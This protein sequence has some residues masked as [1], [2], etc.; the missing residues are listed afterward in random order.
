MTEIYGT[1]GPAC[2]DRATLESMLRAGMTGM[3]LN[4][5]HCDLADSACMIQAFHEAAK[6]AGTAPQL[7]I[8]IQGPELRLGDLDAPKALRPGT[9]VVFGKN[10][11]PVPDVVLNAVSP[12]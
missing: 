2:G 6:S 1:L 5:S 3:R 10:G 11:I 8:D 7:V 12:G 9:M 4:L